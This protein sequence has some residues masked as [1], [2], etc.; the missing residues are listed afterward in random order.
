MKDIAPDLLK[1]IQDDFKERVKTNAKVRNALKAM[2]SKKATFADANSFA[3][4]IGDA[5]AESFKKN[6]RSELLPDERMYYNIA[7]RVVGESLKNNYNLVSEYSADV[8]T[9]LN[10]KANLGLKGIKP[11]YNADKAKGIINRISS[12]EKYED[13]SWL[14]EEPVT[15]FTQSIVDDTIKRNAEF[16][17]KAGLK[18]K[19][20][21]KSTGHCCDWCE[22]VAGEYEYPDVPKDVYRRHRFCRCTVEYDPGNGR[23]QNVHSKKWRDIDENERIETYNKTVEREL[24]KEDLE[25]V[26]RKFL[27]EYDIDIDDEILELN[28]EVTLQAFDG[29]E[30]MFRLY[31][32]LKDRITNIGISSNGVMNCSGNKINFN[33]AYFSDNKKLQEA[34]NKMSEMG[35]W[36]KN[37]SPASVAAHEM[38]HAVNWD[39]ITKNPFYEY[40]FERVLDWNDQTTAKKIVSDACKK[41]KKTEFGKGKKN[42][43]LRNLQ[44]KYGAT[45]PGEAIAEAFADLYANENNANPLSKAIVDEINLL[46]D[47]YGKGGE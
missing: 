41:T 21:R 11:Q 16:Q 28:P 31:P 37:S 24:E 20:I 1:A 27:S 30:S 18:A 46:F 33:P 38:G 32:D 2:K 8:Q 43:E 5:L 12:E 25:R 39:L 19:I 17:Y 36:P 9:L 15:N 3:E 40:D 10:K 14:L 23:R 47:E 42:V 7:D 45:D 13:I 6:I 34:C 26:K 22:E 44:S 35:W 29:I 4:A